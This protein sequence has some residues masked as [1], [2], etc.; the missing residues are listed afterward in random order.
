MYKIKPTYNTFLKNIVIHIFSL[1]IKY[2]TYIKMCKDSLPITPKN[3]WHER[4]PKE[5]PVK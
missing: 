5:I 1:Y 2:Y 3:L 4:R